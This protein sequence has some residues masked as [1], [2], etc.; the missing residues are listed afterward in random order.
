MKVNKKFEN[1]ISIVA[2]VKN[3]GCYLNEWIEYHKLIGIGKF[4]IYDNDSNDDTYNNLKEYIEDGSVVYKKIRG[5]VRQ[6][7][8][9]N[10]ALNEYSFDNRFL[11]FLDIDEFI[12]CN[13]KLNFCIDSLM[14]KSKNIGGVKLNWLIYGSSGYKKRPDGLVT[15]SFLYRS[16]T[17]FFKNR[18]VKTI[19]NP[20]RVVGFLNPHYPIFLPNFKAINV[21]GKITNGPF[22]KFCSL[23]FR[24]NHYFTKSKKEFLA[25][26]ERG[27]ADNLKKRNLKEFD[28]HDRNEIF[29]ESMCL[30]GEKLRQR[31]S[32]VKSNKEKDILK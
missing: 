1:E 22:S 17:N 4:Y 6:L 20:R 5:R 14:T 26:R 23:N 12:Y 18:H 30:Y 13:K 2:I 3:E 29:D 21:S 7:D 19:C 25:K 10:D 24:I 11:I 32:A 9:Y 16:C 27:M 28:V 15:Q 31:L 8:A